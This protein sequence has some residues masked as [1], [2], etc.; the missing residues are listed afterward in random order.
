MGAKSVFAPLLLLLL[1]GWFS[2]GGFAIGGVGFGVFLFALGVAALSETGFFGADG[3][4]QFGDACS[5]A[6]AAAGDT[7]S[8]GFS[9]SDAGALRHELFSTGTFCPIAVS[10]FRRS[11]LVQGSPIYV[12]GIDGV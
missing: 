8:G 11:W 7:E 1:A 5:K 3:A 6:F 10:V 2:S 12:T 4:T 9:S